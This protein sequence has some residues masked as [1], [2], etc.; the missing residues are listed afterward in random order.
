LE[1]AIDARVLVLIDPNFLNLEI[2]TY[3]P[4]IAVGA[5]ATLSEAEL[6][7]ELF[8]AK[9]HFYKLSQFIGID[10]D[11]ITT[12]LPPPVCGNSPSL[13]S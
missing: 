7:W 11:P 9:V 10:L 2:E 1:D 13:R 6:E 8:Q 12:V 5:G 4:T 3:P